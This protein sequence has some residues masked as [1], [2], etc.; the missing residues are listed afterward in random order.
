MPLVSNMSEIISREVVL[1]NHCA[2]SSVVI[3]LDSGVMFMMVRRHSR[4]TGEILWFVN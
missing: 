1:C 3:T 4:H 2:C